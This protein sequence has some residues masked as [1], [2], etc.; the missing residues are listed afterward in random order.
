MLGKIFLL[1]IFLPTLA[2]PFEKKVQSRDLI[3]FC[4][5]DKGDDVAL[6]RIIH[7]DLG[8]TSDFIIMKGLDLGTCKD[9]EKRVQNL[10]KKSVELTLLGHFIIEDKKLKTTNYMWNSLKSKKDC[11]SYLINNCEKL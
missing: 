6:F 8:W 11:V 4:D 5:Y 9:L 1:F 7:K 10:K 2:F 3:V